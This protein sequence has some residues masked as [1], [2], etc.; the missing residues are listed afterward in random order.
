[1]SKTPS[2]VDIAAHA[3]ALTEHTAALKANT[4]A[5]KAHTAALA[6]VAAA[7]APK[8]GDIYSQGPCQNGSRTVWR[9]DDHLQP[10]LKTQ[11]AC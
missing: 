9:Y 11:E 3:A 2:Q 4:R 5:L 10:T 7:G 1:V 6:A 8:P